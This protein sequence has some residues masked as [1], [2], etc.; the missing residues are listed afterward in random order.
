MGEGLVVADFDLST[1]A[2]V[3]LIKLPAIAVS[4]GFNLT[5]YGDLNLLREVRHVWRYR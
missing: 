2:C 4:I 1:G 3:G 5:R